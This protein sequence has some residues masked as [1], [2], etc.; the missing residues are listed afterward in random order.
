MEQNKNTSPLSKEAISSICSCLSDHYR[1]IDI[2]SVLN[3]LGLSLEEVTSNL[4]SAGWYLDSL[5]TFLWR[6]CGPYNTKLM[7]QVLRDVLY[8]EDDEIAETLEKYLGMSQY[9]VLTIC[10]ATK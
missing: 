4:V 8:M 6:A 3:V 10:A 1:E 9:E 2:L 5:V 7:I